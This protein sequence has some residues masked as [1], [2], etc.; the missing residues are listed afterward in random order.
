MKTLLAGLALGAASFCLASFSHAASDTSKS[1]GSSSVAQTSS[2]S[3]PEVKSGSE[4][5]SSLRTATELQAESTPEARAAAKE[6]IKRADADYK[7]ARAKCDDL[8]GNEKDICRAE[9]RLAQTKVKAEANA[10]IKNT[11]SARRQALMDI[12]KAEY[13]LAK[14][15]CDSEEGKAK[16]TCMQKAKTER[17]EKTMER[18]TQQKAGT[19]QEPRSQQKTERAGTRPGPAAN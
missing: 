14:E 3:T 12:A 8:K 6:N 18:P 5:P 15:K 19:A 10:I 16:D 1:S 4:A 11:S 17:A 7:T 13:E 2:A 9:A